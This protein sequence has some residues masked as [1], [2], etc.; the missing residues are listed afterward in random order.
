MH[1]LLI[2]TSALTALLAAC[3]EHTAPT[4]VG[5]PS[6]A[7]V[8]PSLAQNP[9]PKR[10]GT[11]VIVYDDFHKPD[12]YTLADYNAKW[13]TF[14]LGE[15]AI[16]DTRR[17]DNH[18]FSISATPFRTGKDASV[19]DHAKYTALS[20]QVFAVPEIG[21]ITVSI[22][23]AA[24][25]PG[26]VEGRVVH[27]TYVQSGAPYAATVLQGQQAAATL[28]MIDFATG[29]LFDWFVSGNT[30]FPLYERLPSTVSGSAE[31]VGTD[32]MYTQITHE[33]P[34]AAG[35]PHTVAI[36]YS[37]DRRRSRVEYLL[38]GRRV[39]QVERVG[40]P[41]DAQGVKYSG[42]YPSLGPGELL[43]D[44]INSVVIAHGLFS[45]LDAFP[46]QHPEAPALNVSV[47]L[48]ERLFGQGVKANFANVVVT[49]EDKTK[50]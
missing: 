10:P 34:I 17:F 47:P 28:H 1:R 30:A 33:V 19:F 35:V 49:I 3:S 38:D 14:T 13:T 42:I 50:P 36:R 44:K 29:Q 40:I 20:K 2:T 23:I 7:V 26:T 18:T 11:T 16:A 32:K 27:G 15:M 5:G 25:T 8:G 21:S 37:R 41:L 9:N 48:T 31:H 46:F 4:A 45:L 39:F 24:E 12:G 43:R 22:D 6:A